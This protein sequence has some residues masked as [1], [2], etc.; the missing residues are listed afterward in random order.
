M[1]QIQIGVSLCVGAVLF[2]SF[3]LLKAGSWF[4]HKADVF[5]CRTD[6]WTSTAP[7]ISAAP[8]V[9]GVVENVPA[10]NVQPKDR[11][12]QVEDSSL[13][14]QALAARK[15]GHNVD[16]VR[17][18]THS[19]N[20]D[21]CRES[22]ALA[23]EDVPFGVASASCG[24]LLTERIQFST[25]APARRTPLARF[26]VVKDSFRCSFL[27]PPQVWDDRNPSDQQVSVSNLGVKSNLNRTATAVI[28]EFDVRECPPGYSAATFQLYASTA[29]ARFVGRVGK[30]G[31]VRENCATYRAHVPVVLRGGGGERKPSSSEL[32][33]SDSDKVI[34]SLYWT[35]DR[36]HYSNQRHDL[37]WAGH[38]FMAP[39][40]TKK[41]LEMQ[42]TSDRKDFL[43]GHHEAIRGSPF[44]ATMAKI[45]KGD[46]TSRDDVRMTSSPSCATVPI[47]AWPP[48]GVRKEKVAA[49]RTNINNDTVVDTRQGE[50]APSG[51]VSDE[52]WRQSRWPFASAWCHFPQYALAEIRE[53]LRGLRV[54]VLGDSNA[55]KTFAAWRDVA[56]P[57]LRLAG[58]IAPGITRTDCDQSAAAKAGNRT[59]GPHENPFQVVYRVWK[60]VYR[61]DTVS[62]E[63][64]GLDW[65]GLSTSLRN[66][67]PTACRNF[68]GLGLYNATIL[69][70]PTWLFVYES[71][72]GRENVLT[73]VESIFVYCAEKHPV[74]FKKHVFLLQTPTALDSA[75]QRAGVQLVDEVWRGIQN[76]QIEMFSKRA[77]ERLGKYVDGVIP[78]FELTYARYFSISFSS[79]GFCRGISINYN[80]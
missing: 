68:L 28:F 48:V 18:V 65:D 16:D 66:G 78:V 24:S 21:S 35:S 6:R 1:V 15:T 12:E 57:E 3:A 69:S 55:L 14:L 17:T 31:L 59:V 53:L 43:Q 61:W 7:G 34:L 73:S 80:P 47:A 77:R 4:L 54:R 39:P 37:M 25:Y 40:H 26:S 63:H 62:S 41:K 19:S 10:G 67:H 58:T 11:S 74:L 8:R 36:R 45:K 50:E 23:S 51:S 64:P 20:S 33:Q 13:V 29:S 76:Y 44:T 75:P 70:L 49:I 56:C 30:R 27:A 42:L 2:G 71:A 38:Y 52:E 60:A 32:S 22:A 5:P 79:C 46:D 9:G 72:E